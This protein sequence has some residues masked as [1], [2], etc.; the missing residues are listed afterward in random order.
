MAYPYLSGRNAA[1]I[2]GI[3]DAVGHLYTK[4]E[5]RMVEFSQNNMCLTK[6]QF[7]GGLAKEEANLMLILNKIRSHVYAQ[8]QQVEQQQVL[9]G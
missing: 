9:K 8:C 6:C 7:A 3:V 1:A 4:G 5:T 2:P